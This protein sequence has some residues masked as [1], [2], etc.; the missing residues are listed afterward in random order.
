MKIF[1]V[2][3]LAA[4]H[5]HIARSVV[6]LFQT[7]FGNPKCHVWSHQSNMADNAKLLHIF[8]RCCNVMMRYPLVQPIIWSFSATRYHIA[9]K[10]QTQFC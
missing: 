9:R 3:S 4:H 8:V 10:Q 2:S 1:S 5:Q 6:N 7:R